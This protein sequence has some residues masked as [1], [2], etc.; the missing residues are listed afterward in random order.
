[1]G[2]ALTFYYNGKNAQGSEQLGRFSG[3]GAMKSIIYRC[4]FDENN[5]K[6]SFD[7]L[8]T[9]KVLSPTS[10]NNIGNLDP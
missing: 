4:L 1:M 5:T 6:L 2:R 10:N 8:I 3:L 7:F 9:I